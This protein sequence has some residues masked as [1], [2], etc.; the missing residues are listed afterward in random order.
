MTA[1]MKGVDVARELSKEL[2]SADFGPFFG[3][4][5]PLLAPLHT[6]LQEQIGVLTVARE[7]NAI[8]IAAGTSLAGRTPVV[9]MQNAGLGQTVNAIAALVVPYRIP[10]LLVVSVTE[11]KVDSVQETKIMGR[12]TDPL[13]EGLGV[14]V[15]RLDPQEPV[16]PQ[17]D[18][19]GNIVHRRLR[20]CALLVPA[21]TLGWQE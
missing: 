13:L 20:P 14:E 5:C 2:I 8:G 7:D 12:L 3:T 15:V 21:D 16:S 18:V 1:F 19:V 11:A 10:M 17:V 6:A 9:L 4:P